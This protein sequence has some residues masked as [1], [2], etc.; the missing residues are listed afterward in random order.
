MEDC[1]NSAQEL[2][3]QPVENIVEADARGMFTTSLIVAQAFEKEHKNVLR[4]IENLECSALFNELNFEPVD[5]KDAKGEIC[6]R[7]AWDQ[8]FLA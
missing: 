6:W 7:L 3:A 1:Q 4:D 8:F 2:A 5:Y